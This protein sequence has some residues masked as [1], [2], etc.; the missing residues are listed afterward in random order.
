MNTENEQP[1]DVQDGCN[2][3]KPKLNYGGAIGGFIL[4]LLVVG[5]YI[6]KMSKA[7]F[8]DT[9]TVGLLVTIFIFI[10]IGAL[11]GEKVI[12]NLFEWCSWL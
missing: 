6:L 3:K 12:T 9:S 10:A 2:G 8:H 1:H 11:F 5:F 4:G 7:E